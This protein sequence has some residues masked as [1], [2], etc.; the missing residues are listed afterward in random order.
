MKTW[1]GR[2]LVYQTLML[3]K[4]RPHDTAQDRATWPVNQYL[5]IHNQEAK[6]ALPARVSNVTQEIR[7]HESRKILLA[8]IA[9]YLLGFLLGL[10]LFIPWPL[11]LIESILQPTKLA[12][13]GL[14]LSLGWYAFWAW[15]QNCIFKTKS[16]NGTSARSRDS[17]CLIPHDKQKGQVR[18]T[19]LK[20]RT[21]SSSGVESLS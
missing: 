5:G 10:V 12:P 13:E 7:G 21:K 20:E 17:G 2:Y 14:C 18:S 1:A 15:S 8:S 3:R 6:D 16:L 9:L 11:S 4:K 19:R